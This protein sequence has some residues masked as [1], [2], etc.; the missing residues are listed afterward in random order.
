MRGT[1]KFYNKKKKFGFITD[2]EG[3]DVFVHRSSFRNINKRTLIMKGDIVEFEIGG[4]NNGKEQAV[5][6]HPILSL[7]MVSKELA[8]EGLNAMSIYDDKGWHGWYVVDKEEKQV[9]DKEMNLVELA[10]YVGF[11]TEGLE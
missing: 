7:D 10:S 9:V 3:N 6:V 5:N 1:I 2:A 8:K 4:G 11:D